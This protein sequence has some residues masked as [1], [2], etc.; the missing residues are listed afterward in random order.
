MGHRQPGKRC[1]LES[2]PAAI[3]LPSVPPAA[4]GS[5]EVPSTEGAQDA[6]DSTLVDREGILPCIARPPGGLQEDSSE[7]SDGGGPI[8]REPTS[9]PSAPKTGRLHDFWDIRQCNSELS[10]S[11]KKL[12][13]AS[14]RDSTNK[15]YAGAWKQWL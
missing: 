1:E 6:P 8:H 14:W 12:V 5:G 4:T 3:L 10:E 15:R 9:G 7:Q 13:E 11:A 2:I